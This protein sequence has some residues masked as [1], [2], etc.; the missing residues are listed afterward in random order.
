MASQRPDSSN[1]AEI[2]QALGQRA[3]GVVFRVYGFLWDPPSKQLFPNLIRGPP[4]YSDPDLFGGGGFY[5]Q[6][7]ALIPKP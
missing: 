5:N 7:P 2:S 6:N 3:Y 1:S 4:V